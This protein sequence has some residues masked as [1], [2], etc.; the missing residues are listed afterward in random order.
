MS[1]SPDSPFGVDSVRPT[2]LRRAEKVYTKMGIRRDESEDLGRKKKDDTSPRSPLW[3]DMTEVSVIA[4]RNFLEDL[5]GTPHASVMPAAVASQATD[6]LLPPSPPSLSPSA[7]AAHAAHAYQATGKAVHDENVAAYT[8]HAPA[9]EDAI[10]PPAFS[11]GTDFGDTERAL[12]QDYI[13]DLTLLENRGI[14]TLT[15]QRSMTFLE[16][17]QQAIA[18]VR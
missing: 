16:S 7:A 4:L 1:S 15:L 6:T 13:R 8:E 5:L 14:E 18:A 3:D 12:L 11:L 2:I 9:E 17:I 10:S